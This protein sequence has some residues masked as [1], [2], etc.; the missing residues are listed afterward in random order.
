MSAQYRQVQQRLAQGWNTWDVHSVTTQVLLPEGLAIHAGLKHNT[1]EGGDSYLGDALIGR[2]AAGAEQVVPGPHAWDGT[3][4]ELRIAWKGHNWRMQSAREDGDL[5]L[6]A[7]PLASTAT[8]A[9]PPTIVFSVNFL[10]NR[11]GTALKQ[12]DLI[13]THGASGSVPVYCTCLKQQST[14]ASAYI[15]LPIS[16]PYFAAD[17]VEPVGVST[18]KRRTLSEIQ[19]VLARQQD[20]YR[21]SVAAAGKTTPIVHAIETTLGWDTIFKPSR[22]RVFSPV[23]R[24]WS[25]G[26]GGYVLFDWDTFFAATMAGTWTTGC[27]LACSTWTSWRTRR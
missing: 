11:P 22:E 6:L 4:T 20:A 17:L 13:E 10:W 7:T 8:S 15:D 9:L 24:V 25:V 3:Y 26:W 14:A 21:Q 2:L 5:V 19:A 1:T 27:R 12:P 16:G 18:G 23:S